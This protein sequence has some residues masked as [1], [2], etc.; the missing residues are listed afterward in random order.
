MGAYDQCV[1]A[2][3][4]PPAGKGKDCTWQQEGKDRHPI[5]CVSWSAARA[6][7]VHK[8]WRLPEESEWEIA[9][10]GSKAVSFPWGDAPPTC[11]QAVIR[12]G[13]QGGCGTG[14]PLAV[15]SRDADKSWID[16][17]DLGGNV[18]EWTGSDYGAYPGGQAEAGRADKVNR[19]GSWM[20]RPQEM[21]ASHTRGVDAAAEA[22]PD[23]GFRCVAD[24]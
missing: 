9:A 18:R 21:T 12:E 7:C 22:R 16:A 13:A 24:L 15:G 8:G 6:Y 2:G 5:N 19:G 14:G 20:M 4:C 11:E 17:F 3:A 10:R 23:L 1:A